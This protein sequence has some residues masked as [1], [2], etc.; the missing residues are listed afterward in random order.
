MSLKA[1]HIFFITASTLL[2]FAFSAWLVQSYR[3]SGDVT[4]LLAG[5]ASFVA[6]IGLILYSIKFRRKLKDVSML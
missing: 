4:Q 5:A 2:A 1:F 6:G 3:G